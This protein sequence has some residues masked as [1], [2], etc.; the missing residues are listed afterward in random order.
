MVKYQI[1]LILVLALSGCLEIKTRTT[2]SEDGSSERV[3]TFQHP[4]KSLPEAAYPIPRDS[5]WT[6]EWVERPLGE[7]QVQYEYIARKRFAT[8]EDLE[9]EYTS[10]PDTGV[11]SVKVSLSKRFRW[12][13]TYFDYR[14]SYNLRNEFQYIP[15]TAV[16][17]PEQIRHY[18]YSYAGTIQDSILD[19]KVRDWHE[20]NTL[21]DFYHRF[22]RAMEKKNHP[23]L[24]ALNLNRSKEQF[25]A[26]VKVRGEERDKKKKGEEIDI[27][28]FLV[29]VLE[30]AMGTR[31]VRSMKNEIAAAFAEEQEKEQR[32]NTA[33]GTYENSVQLPGM[34]LE[35]NSNK[36]QGNLVA[37]RVKDDQLKV[38]EFVMTAQSRVANTWAFVATGLAGITV[39]ALVLI[40]T[41]RRPG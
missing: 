20:R 17:T 26:L 27:V 13:Y 3:I 4:K 2:V 5:S 7:G 1:V 31:A 15:I 16:L 11:L 40:Q 9:R 6:L 21:E 39:V 33:N 22:V 34:L 30:E 25:F 29:D 32:L 38:G 28:Q 19:T 10:I 18:Q 41:F 35:T 37:W 23:E 12:F 24:S 36:V 14:E 8:P